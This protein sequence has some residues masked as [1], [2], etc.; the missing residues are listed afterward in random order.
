MG[1]FRQLAIKEFPTKWQR[2]ILKDGQLTSDH[3]IDDVVVGSWVVNFPLFNPVEISDSPDNE[4]T[5]KY[6]KYDYNK[7]E[8]THHPFT[9]AKIEDY[10]LLESDPLKVRGEHYD[11]VI[12]GV[13]VGGGSRRIHD[14]DLQ[15]YIFE[16]I[17]QI[18]NFQELFGHLLK[19]LSMGCPPH[20]GLALG[21]DR[22][23][24]MLIG[25][26]SIR[27]VIA[28]P[29]T[30]QVLIQLLRVQLVLKNKL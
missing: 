1:K 15:Q 25:S 26:N 29:K 9:M 6:P 21:F 11:L 16:E 3:N 17:L 2:P 22:L 4:T 30:N 12:N 23:C 8:S 24:A 7:F 5:I 20:A 10:E 18:S 27:D 19:A 28:F 13:E 14:P